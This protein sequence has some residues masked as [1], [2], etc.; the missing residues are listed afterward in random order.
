MNNIQGIN[1]YS[2]MGAV[3]HVGAGNSSG[4]PASRGTG[5]RKEDA[6]EISS[7]AR[8]LSDVAAMPNIRPEKVEEVRQALADGSYDLDGKVGPAVERMIEEYLQE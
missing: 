4:T 6:V 8:F 2:K 3:N 5:A 1:G 7:V